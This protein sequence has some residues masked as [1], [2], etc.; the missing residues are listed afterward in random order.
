MRH[1][2]LPMCL[3]A[4]I[5]QQP[6]TFLLLCPT[7]RRPKTIPLQTAPGITSLTSTLPH[8]YQRHA[9]STTQP[10][11]QNQHILC[12]RHQAPII[13]CQ[14]PWCNP[15]ATGMLRIPDRTRQTPR[16]VFLPSRSE[17]LHCLPHNSRDKAKDLSHDP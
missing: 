2:A 3:D 5:Q 12:R 15:A 7:N 6:N 11:P 14:H 17:L 9:R 13:L 4:G 16:P 8:R 10:G 1:T